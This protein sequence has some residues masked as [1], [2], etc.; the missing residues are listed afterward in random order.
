MP[1][2][3]S[4]EDITELSDL[5]KL[6]MGDVHPDAPA[7]RPLVASEDLPVLAL[8]ENEQPAAESQTETEASV[9]NEEIAPV[10]VGNDEPV[11]DSGPATIS[12]DPPDVQPTLAEMVAQL[13]AAV[14]ERQQQL[15]ELEAVAAKLGARNEEAKSPEQTLVEDPAPPVRTVRPPLE[16]VPSSPNDDAIDSALEAALATLHRMNGTSR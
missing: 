10:A 11:E 5:P 15:Q 9:A 12:T 3:K 1:W 14:A 2:K 4:D 8:N 7:R 16:A 13:E 6:R